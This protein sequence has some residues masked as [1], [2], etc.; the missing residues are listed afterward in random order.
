MIIFIAWLISRAVRFSLNRLM[1]HRKNSNNSTIYALQKVLHY[2]I[3]LIGLLVAISS[4]GVD[5]SKLAL[6][7]SALSIGIGFGLQNR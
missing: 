4:I 7:A 2:I 3:L 6:L 1:S 5:L